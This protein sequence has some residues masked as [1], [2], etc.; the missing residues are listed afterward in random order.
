MHC[1]P[2]HYFI[3]FFLSKQS[4][5]WNLKKNE[6]NLRRKKEKMALGV[7]QMNAFGEE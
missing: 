5:I 3:F 4:S 7:V 1:L 6:G 2:T